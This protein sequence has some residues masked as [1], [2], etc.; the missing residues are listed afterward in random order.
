MQENKAIKTQSY[1]NTNEIAAHLDNVEYIIMAAPAPEHFSDT[2]IHVSIFL[3]TSE[4]FSEDIKEL[5]LDK[6]C[7][8]YDITKSAEVMSQ[9]MPVGFALT[10]HE[11][12]M[13][14]LLIKP[15]DRMSIPSV[16]M[17]VIDFLADSTY[18]EEVKTKSLTG[19]SYIYESK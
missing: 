13:P 12:P 4:N 15:Q 1:L 8:D 14:M 6:F 3:N 9:V 5:I 7:T 17:H 10:S 2:P 19:W 11:T 18:F 16:P